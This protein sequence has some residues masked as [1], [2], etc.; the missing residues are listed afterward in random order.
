M[1]NKYVAIATLVIS[2]ILFVIGSLFKIQS[3]EGGSILL[4]SSFIFMLPTLFLIFFKMKKSKNSFNLLLGSF[5][6]FLIFLGALLKIESYE[7]SVAIILIGVIISIIALLLH[8]FKT[9]TSKPIENRYS[10]ILASIG[11]IGIILGAFLKIEC[12]PYG[13]ELMFIGKI[14]LVLALCFHLYALNRD[15]NKQQ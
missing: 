6:I 15:K 7:F 8:I 1:A 3:W 10:N 12:L 11:G 9:L 14:T 5:G 2:I 13:A 4:L